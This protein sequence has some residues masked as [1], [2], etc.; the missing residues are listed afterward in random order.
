MRQIEETYFLSVAS[1]VIVDSKGCRWC[2][3]LWA[4]DLALHLDYI[5]NLTL[6]CPREFREPNFDVSMNKPP[7]DRIRY[8][9]LP[10]PRNHVEAL[11]K[12]PQLIAKMWQG[13]GLARLYR[14]ASA[15]GR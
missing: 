12:L 8:I 9:D 14:P 1:P 2:N 10:N 5:A 13:C 3:E 7:F 15:A 6:G 11:L 4:K